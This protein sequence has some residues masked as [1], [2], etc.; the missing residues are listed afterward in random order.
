MKGMVTIAQ[1][2]VGAAMERFSLVRKKITKKLFFFKKILLSTHVPAYVKPETD[3]W[4]TNTVM[5]AVCLNPEIL[6]THT[7]KQEGSTQTCAG[8]RSFHK[9]FTTQEY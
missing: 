8:R 7:Y 1:I 5:R 6:N 9:L 3:A 4:S 2:Q